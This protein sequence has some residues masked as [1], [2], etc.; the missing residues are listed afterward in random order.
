M[1]LNF[2]ELMP[3]MNINLSGDYRLQDLKNYAEYL[4]D[5]VEALP[6]ISKVDIQGISDLEVEIEVDHLRAE[7]DAGQLQRHLRRHRG[8]EHDRVG[9]RPSGGRRASQC[10]SG[11]RFH[12]HR[13]AGERHHQGR[14]WIHC[15][16]PR[17]GR[18]VVRGERK[19]ELRAG[20]FPFRWCPS[21]W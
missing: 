4:E 19:G 14:E 10:A 21:T 12:E 18:R 7:A 1:E 17:R 6:Q 16:P 5:R 9:R 3:V 13:R 2:S 8:R 11:R 15:A 20:V